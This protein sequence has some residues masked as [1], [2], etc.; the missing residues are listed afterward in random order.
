MLE[1]WKLVDSMGMTP[2]LWSSLKV[3]NFFWKNQNKN[4]CLVFISFR[5]QWTMHF[6]KNKLYVFCFIKKDFC[7]FFLFL[8]VLIFKIFSIQ[9]I[10][11]INYIYQQQRG[12]KRTITL[13][14]QNVFFC[15]FFETL[16][17]KSIF[18]VNLRL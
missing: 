4:L 12:F 3:E 9:I 15:G 6:E 8:T 5:R 14:K 18:V 7:F 10:V 11:L 2:N 16:S 1:M 17:C 13:K